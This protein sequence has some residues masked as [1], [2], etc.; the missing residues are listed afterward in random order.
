MPHSAGG[1]GITKIHLRS[2]LMKNF[3][4]FGS[5]CNEVDGLGLK[6]RFPLDFWSGG[7]EVHKWRKLE[8]A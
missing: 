8:A 6:H 1:G 3:V 4:E 5:I 7:Y 2:D